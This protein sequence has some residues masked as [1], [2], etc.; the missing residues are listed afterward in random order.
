MDVD[1]S[2][3]Y[4]DI[5]LV[6]DELKKYR[7]VLAECKDPEKEISGYQWTLVAKNNVTMEQFRDWEKVDSINVSGD[8]FTGPY[9]CTYF[10]N[11]FWFDL[12]IIM[13]RKHSS[14]FQNHLKYIHNDIV[15]P[16]RVVILQYA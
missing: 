10:E 7:Q 4:T 6:G 8:L 16:F 11:D 13:W 12:R 15:N 1:K 5:I 3:N 9:Y 2:I 14:T